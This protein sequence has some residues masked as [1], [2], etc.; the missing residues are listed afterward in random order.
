MRYKDGRVIGQKYVDSVSSSLT[1]DM[2]E[3]RVLTLQKYLN[4]YFSSMHPNNESQHATNTNIHNNAEIYTVAIVIRIADCMNRNILSDL[5]TQ[6][7]S[8]TH[9]LRFVIILFHTSCIS[10]P[11]PFVSSAQYLA[12]LHLCSTGSPLVMW[13][14]CISTLLSHT[15]FPIFINMSIL[16]Y[17]N[18][19]FYS[20]DHCIYSSIQR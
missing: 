7:S 14:T 4:K 1:N 19:M 8:V 11:L 3:P 15:Q 6:L 2:I 18:D 9:P 12:C 20:T 10:L 13:D 16:A 17:I 5:I